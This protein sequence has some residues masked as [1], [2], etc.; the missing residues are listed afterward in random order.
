M[1]NKVCARS[2]MLS[3]LRGIEEDDS[4]D[5]AMIPKEFVN[6]DDS[7]DESEDYGE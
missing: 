7:V 6:S 1:I 2:P 4:I 5:S 3:N